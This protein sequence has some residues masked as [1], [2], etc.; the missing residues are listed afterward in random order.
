[1]FF[2]RIEKG[3]FLLSAY[4]VDRIVFVKFASCPIVRAVLLTAVIGKKE[5]FPGFY[6][7][8][9]SDAKHQ[10]LFRKQW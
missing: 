9:K 7:E 1:M 2:T 10:F 6:G 5:L 8:I 4:V 3:K